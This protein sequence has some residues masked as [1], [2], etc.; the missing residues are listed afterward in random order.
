M[1]NQIYSVARVD[2][3]SETYDFTMQHIDLDYD[4]MIVYY[5]NLSNNSR[6]QYWVY[7]Q[8]ID[9]ENDR[10]HYIGCCR[11]GEYVQVQRWNSYL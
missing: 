11:D 7:A 4:N 3:E 1:S 6:Y 8:D 9:N 2:T 5:T 10:M